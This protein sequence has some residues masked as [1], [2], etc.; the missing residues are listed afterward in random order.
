MIK[1]KTKKKMNSKLNNYIINNKT[2]KIKLYYTK[3]YNFV[4][5]FNIFL[6]VIRI[7]YQIIKIIRK[8]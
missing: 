6:Y 4:Y 7:S 5:I 2:N 1:L 8:K 3:F